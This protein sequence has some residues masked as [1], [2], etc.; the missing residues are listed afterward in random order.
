MKMPRELT[1]FE[2]YVRNRLKKEKKIQDEIILEDMMIQL[3]E[4]HD[5]EKNMIIQ[6]LKNELARLG[7]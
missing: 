1:T 6:N 7:A 2:I 4:Q 3:K 5:A